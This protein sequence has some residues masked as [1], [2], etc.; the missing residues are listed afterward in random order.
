MWLAVAVINL[1]QQATCSKLFERHMNPESSMDTSEIIQ[2]W[3]YP[4]EQY[5]VLTEDGYF[6]LLYRIPYGLHSPE[7][8]GHNPAVLFVAGMLTDTRS[9]IMNLPNNSLGFVI[10]DAGYDVW[11][12]NSRGTTWSR[13]HQNMSIE[14]EEFWDFSFH[15]TGIYDIPAAI[16]FILTKTKQETLYYI[17]HSQGGS[18]GLITFS[19]LP[20]VAK[21]VKLQIL[22]GPSY[23][24]GEN[25][26]IVKLFLLQP[27]SFKRFLWGNKEF[28][29][30]PFD[31]RPLNAKVCSYPIIDKLCV[32]VISMCYGKN[33]KNINASRTDIYASTF[34]D[35]TSMKT[36]IHWSQ[37]VQSGEFK[38][39][40]YGSKNKAVYNMTTP[41]FYKVEDVTVPTA[42]WSGENDVIA[43][44]EDVKLLIPQITSLVFH[45]KIPGWQHA[46]FVIGLDATYK[47]YPDMLGLMEKYK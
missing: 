24:S 30:S 41:P 43:N 15:E 4:S 18:L 39:F 23:V 25:N 26:G 20:E 44:S 31:I 3:R 9:W 27:I 38:Y 6:L 19:L 7:K 29:V 5:E 35:C 17:G 13:R 32:Q 28:C 12:L 42:V 8:K 34:P 45:K 22:L 21:K 1:I 33:D 37:M 16:N 10:A 14:Q 46:D 2:Y 47:L 40:D 36:M 11:M